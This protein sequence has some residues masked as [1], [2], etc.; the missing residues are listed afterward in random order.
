MLSV[1]KH[2]ETSIKRFLADANISQADLARGIE[3]TTAF[4]ALLVNE[5]TGPSKDTIDSI[6]SFLS[7]RLRRKVTYEQV[8]APAELAGR[9]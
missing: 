9:R 5:K 1:A 3:K 6:L 7:K 8:F 4:V 2:S